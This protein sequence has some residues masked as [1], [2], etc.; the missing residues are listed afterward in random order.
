M[1]TLLS[2]YGYIYN[3]CSFLRSSFIFKHIINK[4]SFYNKHHIQ[5]YRNMNCSI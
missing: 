4:I 5:S 2:I 1:S 3:N